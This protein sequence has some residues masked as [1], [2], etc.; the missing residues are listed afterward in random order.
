MDHLPH[1]AQ[2]LLRVALRN[3]SEFFRIARVALTSFRYRWIHRC[4]GQN[5]VVGEGTIMVNSAN[6][7]I[8]S[9]CLLQD[10]VYLRAGIDGHIELS[11]G[12]ALNSFVQMYGHGGIRI[13]K[14][15][16]IGPSTVITTTG[17]DY[18]ATDLDSEYAGITIGERVWV[19]A[20][21]T[22]IGG[23]N[24]GDQVVIGAGA[25]VTKDVPARCLA[26]GVPARIVRSFDA[27]PDENTNDEEK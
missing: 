24:I 16:Q 14:N 7:N 15:S 2:Y 27:P 19:G 3:P 5:T 12:V 13:G 9:N 10:R 22:I 23:V 6:I 4:V 20:N 25:V 8:G 26:V 1:K 11:D 17:H 21:C 18:L